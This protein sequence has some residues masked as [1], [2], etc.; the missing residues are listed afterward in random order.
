MRISKKIQKVWREY[1][2]DYAKIPAPFVPSKEHIKIYQKIINRFAPQALHG[3]ILGCTP[4]IRDLMAGL[5]I[6]TTILD[7]NNDMIQGMTQ[8]CKYPEREKIKIGLWTEADKYFYSKH[9][10]V[11]IGHAVTNNLQNRQQ[12]QRFFRAMKKILSPNGILILTTVNAG[13]APYLIEQAIKKV[14]Q[15]PKYFLNL[16]N[17]IYLWEKCAY[18]DPR[19]YNRRTSSA[20]LNAQTNY[21]LDKLSQGEITRKQFDLLTFPFYNKSHRATFLFPKEFDKIVNKYFKIIKITREYQ[22]PAFHKFY[23]VY[24]LGHEYLK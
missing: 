5:K 9:F 18:S 10:D 8:L 11:I 16:Y 21:L 15:N 13:E 24:V 6:R 7:F 3:L 14:N 20:P 23:A 4:R 1:A 19:F 17:K 12:Y 22:H 2:R